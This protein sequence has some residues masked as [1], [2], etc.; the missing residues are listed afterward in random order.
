LHGGLLDPAFKGRPV[1]KTLAECAACHPQAP[2]GSFT[3][4]IYI[5][6]DEVFRGVAR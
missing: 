2:R 6:S 1:V 4:R 3:Q 5:I